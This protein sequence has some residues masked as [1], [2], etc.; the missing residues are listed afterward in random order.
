MSKLIVVTGGS[1]GIGKAIIEKFASQKFDVVTCGR[2]ANDLEALS[3]EIADRHPGQRLFTFVADLARKDDVQ[4]FS[5]FISALERPVDI[6]VNNAGY[7][8]PGEI[9]T[10]PDGILEEMINANLYS[11]YH[12]TRGVVAGMKQ[13]RSGHIFNMCSVASFMAYPNGGSYSIS[14][15]ALLGFSKTLRAELKDYAIKV[16]SV[17]P[18]ATKTRSWD[19]AK[20]PEERFIDAGDLAET[21]YSAW[22]LSNRSVVEEIVI[23]PMLGDI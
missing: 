17:M 20:L 22:S 19:A 23:R 15:F 8:V 14:K 7:F 12:M 18:G 21:I 4:K 16:T 13:K 3:S 9:S 2:N 1:K 11:A 10:E 5:Q 6:L